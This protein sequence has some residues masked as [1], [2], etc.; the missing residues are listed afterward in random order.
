[1]RDHRGAERVAEHPA[2]VAGDRLDRIAVG[3]AF[4]DAVPDPLERGV[5]DALDAD[6]LAVE[7]VLQPAACD[8][9]G[10]AP[11]RR[12]STLTSRCW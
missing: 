10:G 2:E 7:E 1:V 3:E 4:G 6:P 9:L 11:R 8:E 12:G 5:V